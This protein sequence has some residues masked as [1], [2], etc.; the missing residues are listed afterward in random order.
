MKTILLLLVGILSYL[1]LIAQTENFKKAIL[2]DDKESIIK[3]GEQLLASGIHS[4]DIYRRL[5]M[6]YKENSKYE[7]SIEYLKMAYQT[8][9]CNVKVL[10]SLGE[11][12]AATGD[13]D[14]ALDYL[15]KASAVD[16]T[17]IYSLTLQQKIYLGKGNLTSAQLRAVRICKLDSTNFTSFRNLGTIQLR[18]NQQ[19]QAASAFN[20]AISLNP[21]DIYSRIKLCNLFISSSRN[22]QAT[23][24]ANDGL[25]LINNPSS[26]NALVLRRNLALIQYNQRNPDSCISII[27]KL[28]AD[29][30]TLETY[31]YKLAGYS[32]FMKGF[33]DDAA[34]NLEVL[35]R[36][37]PDGDSLQYQLAFT[38]AQSYFNMYQMKKAS[39]YAEVALKNITP[40]QDQLYNA[41]LLSGQ[42]FSTQKEFSSALLKFEEAIRIDPSQ[43]VAYKLLNRCYL[44]MHD[45]RKASGTLFRFTTLIDKLRLQGDK[46]T[47]EQQEYYSLIKSKNK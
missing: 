16:S 23:A 41:N 17:N 11:L 7:K 9:S 19:E 45:E 40:R 25:K 35:Y 33:Y 20:K 43:P 8:D 1:Q 26:Q 6:A 21:N 4:N 30:D 38:I 29:G 10:I 2:D 42:C 28:R 15:N 3:C 27:K 5:A 24:L 14:K 31:T 12:Y 39:Y 47:K 37:S 34:E 32:Y 18:L 13:E 44:D 36:K 46:I 22:D